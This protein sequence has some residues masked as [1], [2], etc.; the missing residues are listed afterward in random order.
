MP[1]KKYQHTNSG[2]TIIELLV[3]IAISGIVLLAITQLFATSNEMY[4]EQDDIANYQQDIRA[5]LGIMVGDIRM[6]GCDPTDTGGAGFIVANASKIEFTYDL[7]GSGTLQ[8]YGYQFDSSDNCIG[9]RMP[10]D[11]NFY[12]L[13]EEDSISSISSKSNFAY[14]LVGSNSTISDAAGSFDD[15]RMVHINVCTEVE[16]KEY[17]FTN[18]IKPRNMGL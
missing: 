7:N 18:T 2:F 14:T 13:T 3:S 12:P 4:H 8:T 6:A 10:S 9:Y 17:C 16:N 1:N 11:S 15:I 5:A